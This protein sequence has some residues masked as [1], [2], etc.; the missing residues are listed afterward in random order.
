L[1]KEVLEQVL[2]VVGQH[3]LGVELDALGRQ[4]AMADAHEHAA[5][6][7]GGLED[8]GQ[9]L[10]VDHERV[11]APDGERARQPG[12]DRAPVVLDHGRLAVHRLVADDRAAE[13]LR[14][15]LVAQAHTERG[16]AGLGEPARDRQADPGLVGRA[17]AGRD[18]GAVVGAFDQAV[19]VG[20]VVAEDLDVGAE[21]AQV[22]DEVVG[23]R[24]V[25]VHDEDAHAGS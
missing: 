11:V 18:H 8:V 21:L 3:R 25:V 19:G 5:A 10:G 14:H 20:L 4:A 1:V 17:R 2:A 13:G 23:E 24:V 16:H 7:G 22:L 9:R 15:R 6:A 12:E